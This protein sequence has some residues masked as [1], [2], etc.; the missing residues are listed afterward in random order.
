MAHSTSSAACTTMAVALLETPLKRCG[1][2]CLLPPKDILKH[3]LRSDS[4]TTSV[5]VTWR[6]PSAGSS[7]PR[8]LDTLG[9]QR[10][11]AS[12]TSELAQQQLP[13]LS[14]LPPPLCN[15]SSFNRSMQPPPPRF[16]RNFIFTQ[17]HLP[18]HPHPQLLLL[19]LLMTCDV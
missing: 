13:P 17:H 10:L 5:V 11:C 3:C 2:G 18:M 19:L 7:A 14:L 16:Y 12:M 8:Q 15:K 4:V 6:K 1:G 9:P